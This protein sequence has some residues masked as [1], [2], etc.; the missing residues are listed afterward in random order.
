MNHCLI[1]P[2]FV[3]VSIHYLNENLFI[4]T[5]FIFALYAFDHTIFIIREKIINLVAKKVLW[6]I[7][8]TKEM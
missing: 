3:F 7:I 6:K 4:T 2:Y 1:F 5:S 8:V